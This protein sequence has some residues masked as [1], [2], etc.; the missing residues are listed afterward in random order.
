V[1]DQNYGRI[2]GSGASSMFPLQDPTSGAGCA[3]GASRAGISA[4]GFPVE[5][6]AKAMNPKR[7]TSVLRLAAFG[8][9][10]LLSTATHRIL[11]APRLV[12]KWSARLTPAAEPETLSGRVQF[13][14]IWL[15]QPILAPAHFMTLTGAFCAALSFSHHRWC[16]CGQENEKR[17]RLEVLDVRG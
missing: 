5:A 13:L 15:R 14:W 17:R 10:R 9:A 1:I 11:T 4:H 8:A 3:P 6:L 2:A 16:G 7:L 12:S